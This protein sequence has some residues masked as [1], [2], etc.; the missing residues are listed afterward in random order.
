MSYLC[1]STRYNM[2]P[3]NVVYGEERNQFM[4]TYLKTKIGG[5]IRGQGHQTVVITV[6]Y[7]YKK[8]QE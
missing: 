8:L 4:K 3:E 1:K 7:L 2:K 6:F 5:R